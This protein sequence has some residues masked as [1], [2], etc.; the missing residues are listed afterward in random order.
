MSAPPTPH[1]SDDD[2]IDLRELVRNLWQRR[3]LIISLAIVGAVLGFVLSTLSTRYV[4]SALLLTPAV[5]TETYSQYAAALLSAPRFG[6]FLDRQQEKDAATVERLRGLQN[7]PAALAKAIS[8]QFSFTDQDAKKYGVKIEGAGTFVGF[9]L[10]DAQKEPS[11]GVPVM[12]L[13]E[14]VRDTLIEVGLSDVMLPQCLD[15]EAREQRMR[16]EQ[17]RD[18]FEITQNEARAQ[19][20]RGVIAQIPDTALVDNRQIVTVD[21]KNERFLSPAAQLVGAEVAILELRLAQTER[22]RDRIAARLKR[23]YYCN[24]NTRLGNSM[25]GAEFLNVL[26]EVHATVFK[27]QDMNVPIVAQTESELSYQRA[28][29]KRDYVSLTRFV[30]PPE[31]SEMRERKVGRATALLLGG[32]LG[33]M[34]GA[35]CAL[36]IGWWREE[37]SSD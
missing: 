7:N 18:A 32:V 34:L 10:R 29:W 9:N 15:Y 13:S 22:E 2:E 27:D 19:T 30:S 1:Y 26:N 20:L 3:V 16:T 24:A 35:L 14:Y 23:D 6:A 8:P 11:G 33:G 17:L 28:G 36:V 5:K 37:G 31:A 12:L 25:S 21:E 4:S